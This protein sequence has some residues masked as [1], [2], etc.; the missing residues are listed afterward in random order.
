MSV[1]AIGTDI[2]SVSRIKSI[3]EHS[4]QKF[5]ERILTEHEISQMSDSLNVKIAYL[6]KRWAAKEAISKA[7]GTGIGEKLSFQDL[8]I[9]HLESG[10]PFVILNARAKK[11]AKLK[12]IKKLHISI[13]DEKKYAV[14]FVVASS[15]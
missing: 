11:L 3:Y 15:T 8:E 14:A 1:I 9:S 13:S 12:G 5:V 6:S 7:F 10:Q 2:V 4:G